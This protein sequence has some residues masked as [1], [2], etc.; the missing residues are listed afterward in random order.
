MTIHHIPALGAKLETEPLGPGYSGP[1]TYSTGA[2][3]ASLDGAVSGG[4]WSYTGRL[5]SNNP[6]TA[7]QLWVVLAGN[8]QIEIAGS[9]V[10]AGTG[11]VVLF[12]APYPAKT[13]EASDD[14]RAIWIAVPRG[15]QT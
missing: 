8:L 6:G 3:F 15:E 4:V 9:S 14:F 10:E 11:D 13:I 2:D 5:V 1:E 12:E 7:H